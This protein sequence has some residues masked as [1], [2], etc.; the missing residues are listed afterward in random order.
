MRY[1]RRVLSIFATV[2][3]NRVE[4]TTA[5]TG[6]IVNAGFAFFG[7]ATITGNTGIGTNL[8]SSLGGGLLSLPTAVT[9]GN[10]TILAGNRNVAQS[11]GAVAGPQDCIGQFSSDTR[12]MLIQDTTSCGLPTYQEGFVLG[13]PPN[14]GPL[15]N[16]GGPT[17]TRLP[18]PGSPAIDAGYGFPP[19]AVDACP[20][21]DQ[22]G[23][24]RL[25]CDLGAVEVEVAVPTTIAVTTTIDLPDQKPGDAICY[26]A[27][28]GCS[29]RA[30]VMEANR[31]PGPQTITV[32][33]GFFG[34]ATP[35][36]EGTYEPASGGDLD[37]RGETT[38]IGDS[39]ATTIIDAGGLSRAFEGGPS[40][41]FSLSR[42]TVQGGRENSS[43]GG[44]EAGYYGTASLSDMVIQNNADLYGGGVHSNGTL[45]VT[46]STITGNSTSFGDGGGIYAE[47]TLMLSDSRVEGNIA[48]SG[49]GGVRAGTATI[50]R[51]T[52]AGNR[53]RFGSAIGGGVY[54]STLTMVDSTV[55]GNSS[56]LQGGGVFTSGGSI[57][58]S[59]ISGNTT[60]TSGGGISTNGQLT[61]T[62]TTVAFNAAS[63]GQ[64]AQLM[65]FGSGSGFVFHN[66]IIWT[67]KKSQ[68]SCDGVPAT[69]APGSV[70]YDPSCV[71]MGAVTA[72]PRLMPLRPNG[73]P[74]LTHALGT[75]SSALNIGY[76][77]WRT[78]ADER[79][80]P[81]DDV[82]DAGAYERQAGEAKATE[83]PIE[84]E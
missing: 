49:G 61:L 1:P 41:T 2:S 83:A 81:R 47:S 22:R 7:S 5:G 73:G 75:R 31:L 40:V 34:L 84:S 60:G 36:N 78:D 26:T 18:L 68:N 45:T 82:P 76:G 57:T 63:S 43:G 17:E 21:N 67:G 20:A 58:N 35:P 14:L 8:A 29:L 4:Y 32:P 28:S 50:L 66:S 77:K 72:D 71:A 25:Y 62:H 42:M 19:P 46:N 80:E 15:Q 55:S 13:V 38:I 23:V 11:G 69:N 27:L 10:N 6:G 16:N 56:V 33:A 52:I 3:D 59:T 48:S 74:T 37:L 51:T 12:Y 53:A 65:A 44:I 64:G 30:A 70:I 24:Q 54:V 79:G 39:A 9:V